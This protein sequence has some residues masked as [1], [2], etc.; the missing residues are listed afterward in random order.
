MENIEFKVGDLVVLKSGSPI[1]MVIDEIVLVNN[2]RIAKCVWMT[3]GNV[4][5][6]DKFPLTS[7]EPE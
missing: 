6:R 5:H 4:V 3:A 2:I 7:L 1:T